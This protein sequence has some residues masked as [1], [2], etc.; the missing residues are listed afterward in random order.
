MAAP[1]AAAQSKERGA[2]KSADLRLVRSGM[3]WDAA[4]HNAFTD[5]YRWKDRWYCS[6]REGTAH[7]SYDG[8]ARLLGSADG[9]YGYG[10]VPRQM[11]MAGRAAG[12]PHTRRRHQ[13][14]R[15]YP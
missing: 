15:F 5:L 2:P 7:A 3:I 9:R 11:T 6:F 1:R 10:G 14:P 8:A 12:Q 4:P 13:G